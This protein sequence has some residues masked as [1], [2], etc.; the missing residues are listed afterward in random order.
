MCRLGC[1]PEKVEL[2]VHLGWV[3][4]PVYTI[5]LLKNDTITWKQHPELVG[6]ALDIFTNKKIRQVSVF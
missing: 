2:S 6:K 5:A 3:C 4:H 1:V